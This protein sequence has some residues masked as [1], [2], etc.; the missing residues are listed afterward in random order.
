[1]KEGLVIASTL[2]N[3]L[4]AMLA[5]EGVGL[6]SPIGD[7]NAFVKNLL[8]LIDNQSLR[9]RLSDKGVHYVAAKSLD[10]SQFKNLVLWLEKPEKLRLATNE[11]TTARNVVTYLRW[12]VA[13]RLS[14]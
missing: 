8:T 10:N 9:R 11:L 6:F 12:S 7:R 3:D 4:A 14:R 5:D 13:G 1:M 2:G